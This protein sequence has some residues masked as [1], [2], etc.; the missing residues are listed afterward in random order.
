MARVTINLDTKDG[1][2][3]INLDWPEVMR[4]G[5]DNDVPRLDRLVDEAVTRLKRA[6]TPERPVGA[7]SEQ[8]R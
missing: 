7:E 1:D 3:S 8:G 4:W 2:F 5:E 6:Y